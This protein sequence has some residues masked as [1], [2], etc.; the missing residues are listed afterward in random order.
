[1]ST[2]RT[3]VTFGC[4]GQVAQAIMWVLWWMLSILTALLIGVMIWKA[5]I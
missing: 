3:T 5:V 4:F 1:M 2:E